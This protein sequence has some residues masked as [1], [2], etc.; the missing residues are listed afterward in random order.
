MYRA[1][2]EGVEVRRRSGRCPGVTDSVRSAKRRYIFLRELSCRRDF[3][4]VFSRRQ[5]EDPGPLRRAKRYRAAIGSPLQPH[6]PEG[7]GCAPVERNQLVARTPLV[8][9][10]GPGP[11][12]AFIRRDVE[13]NENRPL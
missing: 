9:K 2:V 8:F 6:R 3:W 13:Q 7:D 10:S 4:Q 5:A 12:P 11:N 1:A